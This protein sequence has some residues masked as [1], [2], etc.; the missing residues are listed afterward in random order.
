MKDKSGN[1]RSTIIKPGKV[2]FPMV[3]QN[4]KNAKI[5]L[6]GAG[7]DEAPQCYKNLEQ[8]LKYQGETIKV[9]FRLHPIGVAMAGDDVYDPY[10]D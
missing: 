10:R 6:R 9:L 5:E 8:V 1:R 7:A 4:M 2:D 3:K